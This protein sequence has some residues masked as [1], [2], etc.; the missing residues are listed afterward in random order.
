MYNT[1]VSMVS[2]DLDQNI[3]SAC[4]FAVFPT[5][6]TAMNSQA[7]FV[8]IWKKEVLVAMQGLLELEVDK[9]NLPLAN[10]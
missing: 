8:M 3:S 5:S 4:T 1:N 6:Y 7:L 10:N 2:H 9:G